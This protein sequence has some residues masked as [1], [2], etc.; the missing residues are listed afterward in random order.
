[1]PIQKPREQQ[2]KNIFRKAEHSLGFSSQE[3]MFLQ[4]FAEQSLAL[5][6]RE[7]SIV[8][9][10]TSGLSHTMASTM[11]KEMTDTFKYTALLFLYLMNFRTVEQ[12][13]K[14]NTVTI[15]CV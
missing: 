11:Y 1:M 10:L 2:H 8:C 7:W 12:T 13:L 4:L 15:H 9:K 14:E 5:I 6:S 3:V